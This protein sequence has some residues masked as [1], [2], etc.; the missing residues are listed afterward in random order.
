MQLLLARHPNQLDAEHPI[1]IEN[2]LEFSE[3]QQQSAIDSIIEMLSDLH[4]F[5]Q[6]SR[7]LKKMKGNLVWELKTRSRGGQKGGA[8]VYLFF[9]TPETETSVVVVNA[10]IKDDNEPSE[11]KLIEVLE[12]ALAFKNNPKIMKERSA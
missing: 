4:Q 9:Y 3:N 10:E 6:D 5:G 11:A 2:L 1:I 8:R 12:V 7:Y